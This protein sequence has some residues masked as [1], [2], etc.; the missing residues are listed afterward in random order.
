MNS[1]VTFLVSLAA[2]LVFS[3]PIKSAATT[4]ALIEKQARAWETQDT[5]ALV[6]D[7]APDAVFKAKNYTFTGVEEISQAAS[8]YFRAFT[9]TKVEIK[10]II[11]EG[12]Q[13]AVEWDWSDRNRQTGKPSAAE[14]AIIFETRDDGKITYWR[15]YIEKK[16]IEQ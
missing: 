2:I 4:R 12:N 1:V 6:A 10:R 9:D 7:F 16:Q 3:L 11:I 15:E 14:D 8:D 5:T 13:G